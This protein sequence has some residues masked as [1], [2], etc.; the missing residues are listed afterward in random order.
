MNKKMKMM[1]ISVVVLF[2]SIFTYKLIAGLM[3]KHAMSKQSKV[4]DVATMKVTQAPWEPKLLAAGSVRA[5]RGVNVTTQLAGMVQTIY[6]TPGARA[7]EN[8]LL[9]QLNAD[10]DIAQLHALEANAQLAKITYV[11]DKAQ[12]AIHAVSKQVVDN[13]EANWKSLKAQVIQQAA[14][15]DKKS[16]RAPFSGK[17][18]INNVNPG[19]F[20]NPG[21]KVV[22]LQTLDPI[23][24]DFYMPQQVLAQLRVGQEV[25]ATSDAY[26]DKAFRGK[27]TTIDP[28]LDIGTRNVEVEATL[29]N[30]DT[31]LMPGMFGTVEVTTGKPAQFI[32][33]P[34]TAISFNPYGDIVY[35]VRKSGEDK[36]G[37]PILIAS[38]HFVITGDTRGEQIKIINGLKVG[39]EVVTSGQLKLKNGSQVAINN[40]I[41]PPNNP[42]PRLNNN[43]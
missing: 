28:V 21:D 41:M 16:I 18:G 10:N 36:Q 23:Y 5:V 42:A 24:I 2:G 1:L 15:V 34:Q 12:Y 7:K 22:T 32:T 20:V 37:K 31:K 6:F 43:H 19:Q 11:R 4:I 38:Q 3:L 40:S 29:A 14:I 25:I 33:V 35:I 9:V 26:P 27:I 13:D 8:E 30:P 17:L 39:D